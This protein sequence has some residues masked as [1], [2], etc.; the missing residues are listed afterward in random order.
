MENT[1]RAAHMVEYQLRIARGNVAL[2][3]GAIKRC[4]D[5]AEARRDW[6]LVDTCAA[7]LAALALREA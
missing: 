7:Q 6:A 2:V 3:R 4:K 5:L 1:A